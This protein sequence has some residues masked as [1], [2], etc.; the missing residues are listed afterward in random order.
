MRTPRAQRQQTRPSVRRSRGRAIEG[1]ERQGT[2]IKSVTD[3][4]FRN[5]ENRDGQW[6]CWLSWIVTM[7][8]GIYV[9][10]TSFTEKLDTID[11]RKVDG[12]R[13]I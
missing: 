10:K 13:S 9:P 6:S 11:I 12:Y 7:A 5:P 2:Q 8:S 4:Q 3:G 1:D